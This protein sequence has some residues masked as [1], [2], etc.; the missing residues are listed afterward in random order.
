MLSKSKSQTLETPEAGGSPDG[1]SPEGS[2]YKELPGRRAR[3]KGGGT[4][5]RNG[6]FSLKL[7]LQMECGNL[8]KLWEKAPMAREYVCLNLFYFLK[9]VNFKSRQSKIILIIKSIISAHLCTI[10]M[11]IY[12]ITLEYG[13]RQKQQ[14]ILNMT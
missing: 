5:G 9:L 14:K 6:I 4:S 7:S 2:K 13:M 10:C 8:L 3:G 12:Y 1:V 11:C